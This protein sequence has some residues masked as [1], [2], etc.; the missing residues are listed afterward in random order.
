MT[1]SRG[2]VGHSIVE[3]EA[4]DGTYMVLHKNKKK[5]S[6]KSVM[7]CEILSLMGWTFPGDD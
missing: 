6:K 1:N 7:Q 3:K 5:C 4:T 2:P